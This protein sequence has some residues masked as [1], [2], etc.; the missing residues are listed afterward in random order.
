VVYGGFS[1]LKSL[2][3]MFCKKVEKGFLGEDFKYNQGARS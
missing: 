3:H 1:T 2:E